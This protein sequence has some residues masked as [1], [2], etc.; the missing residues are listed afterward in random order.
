MYIRAICEGIVG[1]G[2]GKSENKY[3][4]VY[5]NVYGKE[6]GIHMISEKVIALAHT[7][8]LWRIGAA[9]A[10]HVSFSAVSLLTPL[11]A[12]RNETIRHDS[13]LG[14]WL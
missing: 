13:L 1:A 2:W 4:R 8:A 10:E 5:S 9:D 11:S 7:V 6:S 12:S 14:C 3:E